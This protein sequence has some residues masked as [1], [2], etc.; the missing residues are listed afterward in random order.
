MT[1]RTLP[2]LVLALLIVA[3]I[4]AGGCAGSA[5]APAAGDIKKFSSADEIRDYIKNNTAIAAGEDGYGYGES[6]A[7]TDGVRTMVPTAAPQVAMAE[8]AGAA[9]GDSLTVPS[10]FAGSTDHSTTNV[11]VAGVDEPDFVKNDG[12]FIYVITG[13]TL[14]IVDAYP[15]ASAS[16][17]SK[18]DIEDT[19]KDIFIDGNRLVLFTTGT[20][21]A[22]TSVSGNTATAEKRVA[23]PYYG[24]SSLPVTHAIFYDISDRAHPKVLKDYTIDGDYIDAR[25]IGSNMYLVTREQVYTYDLD[26]I[27]VPAVHE[28]TKTV[29]APDVYYFDN[30]ERQYAFTTVS[31][32][33]T[34]GAQEKEAKTYLVGSGNLI[35]VS[36]NAMYITYQHY[37]NVYRTMR[38]EPMLA[39]DGVQSSGAG[40]SSSGITAPVLWEDFNKMSETEKQTYIA[41]MKNAEQESIQKKEIDQTTTAIHKIAISSGA[42]TYI[43]RGDVPGLLESQFS[44]DEYNNNLRVATTS[45]VYTTRGS[46]E[47]NNVFVLD[48]GMKTIGSLTHIAEQEKIYSTR[49]IGDRLY[50]VTYKRVDPFFVI[51]LSTP[52]APK[53]LGKL[54]IPGYSDYLHPYDATHI[55]GIGKETATNDW[56]GVS[57]R[58]LK[59]A[60]FDVTDVENPKQIDKVEIGDAGSDSAALTDHKAFLFNREK[61]LLVIPARVV[62]NPAT[63]TGIKSATTQDIWYGAYVFGVTPE[64]GFTLRGTIQHGTDNSSYYWYGSSDAEVK[65][66]LYIGNVLYTLSAKKILANSLSD[67]NTTITTINLPGGSDVLYPPVMMVE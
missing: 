50:M 27:T 21:D 19:P 8:S 46:Y 3:A 39:A 48:S 47:Y 56:G 67:I 52:T 41:D 29:I 32:F 64:T 38:A 24:S 5:V 17:I 66:S 63:V 35:Y 13:Q 51:D 6:W 18:T 11:Q 43:A 57:T 60:L 14:A 10:A 40:V 12:K 61:N 42:I 62:K 25:L 2:L 20:D 33:E 55:I 49:F 1:R 58:G 37:N 34:T 44:M 30:P 22:D 7:V 54:K 31:S 26:R 4:I 53:I 9:K 28:G 59:L 16:I 15:A 23:M 45:S 65:R 36:E